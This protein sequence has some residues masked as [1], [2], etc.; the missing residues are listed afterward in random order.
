MTQC[1]M[2]MDDVGRGAWEW[3]CLLGFGGPH[4]SSSCLR[5]PN[6]PQLCSFLNRGLPL[7]ASSLVHV[8]TEAELRH[9]A[10]PLLNFRDSRFVSLGVRPN[11][12]VCFT[13]VA[14]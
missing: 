13:T 5:D 4:Y 7:T 8:S 9:L 1:G 6:S 11:S 10:L 3:Y 14:F 12:T 2:E